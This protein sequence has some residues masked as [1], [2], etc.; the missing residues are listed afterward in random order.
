MDAVTMLRTWINLFTPQMKLVDLKVVEIM[1]TEEKRRRHQEL[2]VIFEKLLSFQPRESFLV[3]STPSEEYVLYQAIL[4]QPEKSNC[5]KWDENWLQRICRWIKRTFAL[6]FHPDKHMDD[7]HKR[8]LA[9]RWFSC[10]Q[11]IETIFQ[12]LCTEFPLIRGGGP[13][14]P[15]SPPILNPFSSH[16]LNPLPATKTSGFNYSQSNESF[17]SR[18]DDNIFKET[19][20]K[21]IFAEEKKTTVNTKNTTTKETINL[22]TIET[23]ETIT[24]EKTTTNALAAKNI[25][26]PLKQL[27]SKLGGV[28]GE[29]R[30]LRK[31]VEDKDL[32]TISCRECGDEKPFIK[33]PVEKYRG[34]RVRFNECRQCRDERR[35]TKKRKKRRY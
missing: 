16:I 21:D 10:G 26:K 23:T 31:I 30:S 19:E 9:T 11:H 18:N 34:V 6:D 12:T 2:I 22:N 1:C 14:S 28:R 7:E 24:T 32:V 17:V 35:G 13:S 8:V 33:F 4:S 20:D 25:D 5:D 3:T 29:R 27:S 15:L